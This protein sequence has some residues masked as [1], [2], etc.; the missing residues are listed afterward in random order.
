M[1]S[2]RW[3]LAN[4]SQGLHTQY[5][6]LSQSNIRISKFDK[7]LTTLRS[8]ISPCVTGKY[9][10]LSRA[11]Y[12]EHI[13]SQTFNLTISSPFSSFQNRFCMLLAFIIHLHV[14]TFVIYYMVFF[15]VNISVNGLSGKIGFHGSQQLS[16]YSKLQFPFV[17]SD[18]TPTL[19][20]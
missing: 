17:R 12:S 18:L 3:Y 9:F 1:L 5:Y 15:Q 4:Y 11:C 16:L 10:S 8:N 6:I 14:G 20:R 7:Y 19:H 13:Y 2:R